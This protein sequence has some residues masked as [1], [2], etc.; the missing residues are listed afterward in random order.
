M[1]REDETRFR[2]RVAID[3]EEALKYVGEFGFP[4]ELVGIFVLGGWQ[5]IANNEEELREFF[6]EGKSFSPVGEV[7]L[8]WKI[9]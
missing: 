1:E 3:E 4:V 2:S 7:Q 8:R 9:S 5:R 6:G